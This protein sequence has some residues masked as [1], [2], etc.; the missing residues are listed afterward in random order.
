MSESESEYRLQVL[1]D[2]R[3]RAKK[4]KEEELAEAKKRL[5]V[6][7]QTL[8][9]LR[10]QHSLYGCELANQAAI[11]AVLYLYAHFLLTSLILLSIII[12]VV[13]Q[14]CRGL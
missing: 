2:L 3:E 6:E 13:L 14:H 4:Q 1:L 11:Q 5:H 7:Q 10:K 12:Q 9:D 8:E